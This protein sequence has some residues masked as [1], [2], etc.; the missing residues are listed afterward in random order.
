MNREPLVCRDV[1]LPV[2]LVLA[3]NGGAVLLA[4]VAFVMLCILAALILKNSTSTDEVL[5]DLI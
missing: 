2:Y 4:V 5:P 1:N 3:D